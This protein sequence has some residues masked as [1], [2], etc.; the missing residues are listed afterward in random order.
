M[1]TVDS[2][3]NWRPRSSPSTSTSVICGGST[4]KELI[5]VGR[6]SVNGLVISASVMAIF[7]LNPNSEELL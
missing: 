3:M 2:L 1:S 7:W 6:A 5:L 4:D